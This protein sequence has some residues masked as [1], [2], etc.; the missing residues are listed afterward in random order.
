MD[1]I[2][3]RIKRFDQDLPLP[4]YQTPGAAAF[5]L[6][7]REESVVKAGATVRVPLNVAI[8]LPDGYWG[9]LVA[10][11]SLFKRGLMLRNSVGVMD[12]DFSGDED[13]Y[14]A[15]VHNF[16]EQDVTIEKGDRIVQL[17]VLPLLQFPI[18]AVDH[19]HNP[20]RGGHG[21]TGIK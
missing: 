13:E 19:L 5:D 10:R 3:I 18:Q 1:D 14:G 15:V 12:Q 20:S 9:L 17:V 7:V 4:Q 6:Y 11:S 8:K 16:T 21:T 2:P